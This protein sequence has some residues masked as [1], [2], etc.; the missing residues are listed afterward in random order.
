MARGHAKSLKFVRRAAHCRLVTITTTLAV[1]IVALRIFFFVTGL[2]LVAAPS[3][4][5]LQF[6]HAVGEPPAPDEKLNFFLLPLAAGLVLGGGLLLVG[7]PRL[8]AGSTTPAWRLAAG[9][10]LVTSAFLIAFVAGFSGSVTRIA[11]PA[12]LFVELLAFLAF[13]WPAKSFQ[14]AVANGGQDGD[15]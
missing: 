11:T 7:L 8:V 14:E 5:L 2:A 1:M 9:A 15:G 12:I 6:A 13:I 4:L 10:L 3:H